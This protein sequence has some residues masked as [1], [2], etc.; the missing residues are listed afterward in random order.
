MDAVRE[1]RQGGF[2]QQLDKNRDTFD[3]VPIFEPLDENG[4]WHLQA[5][6]LGGEAGIPQGGW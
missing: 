4:S 6:D 1:G 3:Q 2:G 5:T